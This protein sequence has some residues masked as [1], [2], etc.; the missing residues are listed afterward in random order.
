MK[1]SGVILAGGKSSRMKFNKAFAIIS[2]QPVVRIIIDKFK[3]FFDET[4]IIS[5]EL[6]L[7]GDLGLEVCPD[8]FPGLGPVAGIHSALYHA[9]YDKVF[10]MGCD[11]PFMSLEVVNF[12]FDS[13]AEY[14]SVVPELDGRLQPL[15]AVYSKKCLPVLTACLENDKLKL[16]RVFEELNACVIPQIELEEF[17]NPR[18]IFMNVNDQAALDYA[19]QI[20]GRYL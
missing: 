3:V 11:M 9:R 8:V 12:L 16:I 19:K 14:D 17:G 2:G 10:V 6:L 18:E 13:L 1:K 20:A 15:S 4:L 5:N 7:Y